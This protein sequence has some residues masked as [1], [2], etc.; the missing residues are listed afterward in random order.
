MR[1]HPPIR[2]TCE[3]SLTKEEL[4]IEE[5]ID[6]PGEHPTAPFKTHE[7]SV[8]SSQPSTT[9]TQLSSYQEAVSQQLKEE[10]S[11]KQDLL[12]EARR[13]LGD[14]EAKVRGQRKLLEALGDNTSQLM[15]DVPNEVEASK[16]EIKIYASSIESLSRS[17]GS[18]SRRVKEYEGHIARRHHQVAETNLRLGE[19]R[20]ETSLNSLMRRELYRTV[21]AYRR[22][23][24]Q[25]STGWLATAALLALQTGLHISEVDGQQCSF[26][27][28]EVSSSMYSLKEELTKPSFIAGQVR[29]LRAEVKIKQAQMSELE[30]GKC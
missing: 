20:L 10:L 13:Q 11:R 5:E 18:Q 27:Q 12:E 28:R 29:A 17:I 3:L 9:G 14:L 30:I 15:K 25:P 23:I 16:Q 8:I 6:V 22:L 24:T 4:P 21:F 26:Q 19:L 2:P 1:A 7:Y